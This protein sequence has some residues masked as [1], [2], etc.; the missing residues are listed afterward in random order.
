M[1][2]ISTRTRLLIT[3]AII[4]IALSM[5]CAACDSATQ[6]CVDH[7]DD[8]TCVDRAE[9]VNGIREYWRQHSPPPVP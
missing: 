3:L 4:L 7:P 6:Y 5:V 8:P 9:S 1:T 2:H